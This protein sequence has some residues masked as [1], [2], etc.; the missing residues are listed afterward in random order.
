MGESGEEILMIDYFERLTQVYQELD[1]R[2]IDKVVELLS[3]SS[4]IFTFGNGGSA[5]T[6]SHFACDLSK[7]VGKKAICLNDSISIMTAWANDEGYKTIFSGQLEILGPNNIDVAIGISCSGKSENVLKGIAYCND[8]DIPTVGLTSNIG[9][10]SR[11]AFYPIRVPLTMI[12]RM[13]D[14]HLS[15]CHLICVRLRGE[16]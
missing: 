13:E 1:E 16:V 11:L 2:E 8:H 12:E 9:V 5:S 7:R 15:I 10:L 14:V 4:R 3:K 6:A